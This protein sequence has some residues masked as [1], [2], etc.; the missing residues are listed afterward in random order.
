MKTSVSHISVFSFVSYAHVQE[1]LRNKFVDR[2]EKCTFVG[3]SDNTNITN[4]TI[5]SPRKKII[6]VKFL[7]DQSWNDQVD[8]TK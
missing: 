3:Y 2:S 8:G 1:E 6:L 5:L 4:Y 7:E